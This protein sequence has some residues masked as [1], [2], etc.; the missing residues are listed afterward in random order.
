MNLQQVEPFHRRH[1]F[2]GRFILDDTETDPVELVVE[3]N[4]LTGGPI[5]GIVRN[6]GSATDV[7]RQAFESPGPYRV[8]S[9]TDEPLKIDV[10]GVFVTQFSPEPNDVVA[11]LLCGV[12]SESWRQ[13]VDP[14]SPERQLFFRL[15][16][17]LGSLEPREIP[18]FSWTGERR[19]ELTSSTLDLGV[20]WPG[21]IEL[22]NE[23]VWEED[24]TP[25]RGRY[26][27]VPTL[28]FQCDASE[29]ALSDEQVIEKA[30]VLA[31]D[32]TLL[33]SFACRH[34]V[35]WYQYTFST[36]RSVYRHRIESS[37]AGQQ[38]KDNIRPSP[39]GQKLQDF[40]RIC[41]PAYQEHRENG[42]DLRLPIAHSIPEA[43]RRYT[44]ERFASAFWGLE[45]LVAVLDKPG[46]AATRREEKLSARL[47][48]LCDSLDVTW[49]DL[50]PANNR[51]KRPKFIETRN[52]V[53]H[54]SSSVNGELV[55]RETQ[56]VSL[57]FERLVLKALGWSE[58]DNTTAAAAGLE[59]DKKV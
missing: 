34:W 25:R 10:D 11:E 36:P 23:Y 41:L 14:A 19:I 53:F 31:D 21:V 43:G 47:Q 24:G 13:S 37:R 56:R 20:P 18:I 45:K 39:I 16:G 52:K 6:R 15:A 40:L 57:L 1:E 35:Y 30:R 8:V 29:E 55:W 54:S 12:V 38:P 33:M 26:A 44:E 4:E 51:R 46:S 7:V 59:I 58:L 32:A 5:T 27:S 48:R 49:R 50:Y 17:G 42:R 3:Y 22:R 9:A 2:T 28:R